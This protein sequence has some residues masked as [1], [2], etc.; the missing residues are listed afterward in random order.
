[1]KR[2][3]LITFAIALFFTTEL[4]SQ[5]YY[6]DN[7]SVKNGLG[8]STI[9]SMIQDEAGYLW[10]GTESGVSKFDG[11]VFVNYTSEEGLAENGVRAIIENKNGDVW[12]GHTGGGI[13]RISE[14]KLENDSTI[15]KNDITGMLI[16]KS[17][18][19]WISTYGEG[20][21]Y[22][23]NSDEKEIKNITFEHRK[24]SDGLSDLVFFMYETKN[25][26]LMF[27]TD[28]G[29]KKFDKQANNFVPY[30]PEGLPTFFQITTILEDNQNN[31]WLGTHNAGLY[32][33]NKTNGNVELFDYKSGLGNNW[34]SCLHEDKNGNIWIGTW[35]GGVSMFGSKE[36]KLFNTNNGLIDNKIRTIIEDREGNILIGTNENGL[37]IYRGE[38]F[39][40]YLK[41]NG[42]L[43][44][45]IWA[46]EQDNYGRFWF[47]TNQGIAILDSTN[48]FSF[49]TNEKD[50]LT[51]NQV[52][53][54]EKDM[55][56]NIWIGTVNGGVQQYYYEKKNLEYNFTVNQYFPQ[57]N[58]LVTAMEIDKTNNLWVGTIDGLIYYEID[59]EAAARLDQTY[60]LAGSDISVIFCDS[61]NTIWVG[62][63]GKGLVNIKDTVFTIIDLGGK[64]T[65]T[66]IAEDKNGKIWIGTEGQG[67]LLCENEKITKTFRT[68][69]GL[70]ADLITLIE[71]DEN[72]DIFIGTNRGLNRYAQ[73]ENVFYTYTEKSGFTAIEVKKNASLID[74]KGNIW[75]GTVKGAVRYNKIF[76]TRNLLEPLT[77]IKTLTVNFKEKAMQEGLIFTYLENSI[78][79]DYNS[80]CLTDPRAVKYKVMLE[81]VD[82]EWRPET[83]Q[84]FVNFP[85]LPHGKF[86]F[87]VIACNNE[88][89]WNENPVT[90]SFEIK[91]P[92][93]KTPGFYITITLI[94]IALIIFYI[95]YRERVLRIENKILEDKVAERTA[96]VTTKNKE[97]ARINKDLTDSI[98]YAKR[99]Q[100]AIL[101]DDDFMEKILPEYSILFKPRDIVSGDFYWTTQINNKLVI[102]AADCTG[103][104][105]PG[106]FMSMLGV[107]F[108]NE[109]VNKKEV[110]QANEVLNQ[111]KESVIKS[112]KQTGKQGEAQ[113]G[114]DIALCI[115]D[116]E[117]KKLQYS[118]AYNPLYIIRN[119][120]LIQFKADRMPIG[121]FTRKS[122]QTFTN[123]EI[124]LEK[125][126]VIYMFSDGY[127]D[128]FGGERGEK[129]K[130]KNLQKILLE[131]AH[132]PMQ[133]QNFVLEFELNKWQGA[134]PQI[135]DILVIGLKI[136]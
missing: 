57:R 77:H 59:N 106:A 128:Q 12:L 132:L 71:V 93:W 94:L 27:I 47:G 99:I 24:G 79:F 108:L 63:R 131:V 89:V 52:R 22:S 124:Q 127:V 9:Y 98:R 2:L 25:G 55:N 62:S 103:H 31:I 26:D 54:L 20:V 68:A 58:M 34:I 15:T 8:Q 110:T 64:I 96:E 40:T 87:K 109:I 81:G 42:L 51:D 97:L 69:D 133:E 46:I 82:E 136:H 130:A 102:T 43:D 16:D 115:I 38:R 76:D 45:Q 117:T 65:P 90:F 4:K 14:N 1:M 75:F 30:R 105:V 29:I 70:L 83:K 53:F 116:L 84:T 86:T 66:S 112:L 134:E 85:S 39:V 6:F 37:L 35:G 5:T 48:Q 118:G 78:A 126:D 120:E 100:D 28:V 114:M 119:K 33:I 101:P 10:L 61:K 104:G 91:P 60:G 3:I 50:Y 123:H 72:N 11:L 80:I 23:D 18:R 19:L 113:D 21:Y 49:L 122:T 17:G 95:K 67:I 92:L 135:D 13:S 73:K 44:D 56:G 88:G 41:E 125:D 129:L 111:L 7:Y 121:I 36:K 32:K 74:Q 107:S